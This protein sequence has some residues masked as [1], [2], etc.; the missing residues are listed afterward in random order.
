MA[1]TVREA[2]T[3]E[4]LR[5]AGASVLA[6]AAHL[7][8]PVRWA[9]VAEAPDIAH[10]LTGGELLLTTGMA[11]AGD[12]AA[13][14]TFLTEVAEAGV[15]AVVIE[16]GRNFTAIPDDM[17]RLAEAR[18]LPLVSLTREARF[19]DVTEAVHRA[20]L[21]H[22]Y[23]LLDRAEQVS[24]ELTEQILDGA[25]VDEVV[26]HVAGVLGAEVVLEDGSHH[27]I[28]AGGEP[29]ALDD[30][31]A[32]WQAHAHSGHGDGARGAVQ[33]TTGTR[34]CTWVDIWIRHERWG[35][36]HVMAM[37]AD[38]DEVRDLLV[39][40]AGAALALSMLSKKDAAHL[41]E[42][43]VNAMLAEVAA[44]RHGSTEELLHRARA[45]GA[46][47]AR[48]RL[49]AICVELG[50]VPIPH[51]Q[52]D[53]I[54]KGGGAGRA[55][56]AP[57][58]AGPNARL[59]A[60]HTVAESLRSS[61]AGHGCSALVGTSGDRL[62]AVIAVPGS[63]PLMA[64]LDELV[65]EAVAPMSRAQVEVAAGAS[66]EVTLDALPRAIDEAM[67][68]AAFAREAT[69]AE[70]SA[71]RPAGAGR[72]TERV[73]H[74]YD[75]LGTYQLLRRLADG[76]D[77]ARFVESELRLLLEHDERRRPKLVPT[78]RA[79]LAHAGRKADAARALGIQRR[80]LY[81][82]MATIESLLG[83]DIDDQQTRTRLTLALQGHEL[84]HAR[85]R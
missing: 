25:D 60:V 69:V 45:L 80:T 18:G 38:S 37:R 74:H 57:Q 31:R 15:A 58:L 70:A 2:L 83:R 46:N 28:A 61:V 29:Q 55:G 43:A 41:V 64:V 30:L 52:T 47:L 39:D 85:Q 22:Q 17:V 66:G 35:R 34:P 84:L 51:A 79:Y 21:R 36:L 48:G 67:R 27:M 75:D 14:R 8:R 72:P 1:P 53:G 73:L 19:V 16:L 9:H 44:G 59:D 56:V 40:R 68:A 13:Q 65:A 33:R 42:R 76:P 50:D 12:P 32:Q 78:L 7:D 6:G 10:L 24:R 63:R 11:I 20:I 5:A 81:Q 23:Q 26:A 62:L 54:G 3:L 82:R 71:A 77:L 49:A 4:P